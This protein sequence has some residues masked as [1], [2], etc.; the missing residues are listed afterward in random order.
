MALLDVVYEE[1]HLH[2][3]QLAVSKLS[4][5]YYRSHLVVNRQL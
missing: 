5:N 3:W 2:M 1:A 4:I